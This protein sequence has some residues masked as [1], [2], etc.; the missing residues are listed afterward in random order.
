MYWL[1]VGISIVI[2][3]WSFI[4]CGRLLRRLQLIHEVSLESLT[5]ERNLKNSMLFISLESNLSLQGGKYKRIELI[6][7]EIKL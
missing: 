7:K 6:E 1:I 4:R 3:L 2:A 5:G